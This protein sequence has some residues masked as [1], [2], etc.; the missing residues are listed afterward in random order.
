MSESPRIVVFGATGYTGRLTAER[1]VALGSR[2]VLAGRSLERL[3]ALAGQL[4]GLEAVRA[5]VLRQNSVFAMVREGDVVVSTVGPFVEWGEPAVRAAIASGAILLD[6]TGEPAF[7]RRVYTEFGPAARRAGATLLTAMG[8][9]YVPGALAGA[10]ALEEAGETA[11]RVDLGYYYFGGGPAAMSA[12]TRASLVGAALEPNFA[13]R[14]GR[15]RS[16]RVATRVRTFSV[17]G[18]DRSGVSIGGAEHFSLPLAYPRLRDVNVYLGWAGPLARGLQAGA[19]AGTVATRV[20]GVRGALRTAGR[21]VARL[22]PGPEPGT[23]PG[24]LSWV[25]AEAFDAAGHGSRRSSSRAS[26]ATTS[27][28]AHWRGRLGAPP[29]RASGAR[30]RSGRSTRSGSRLSRRAARRR[31]SPGSGEQA[32]RPARISPVPLYTLHREQH[33]P[34]TPDDVFR[35]SPT[36]GTSRRSPRPRCAS[37]SSRR[38]RSRCGWAP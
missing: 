19:L 7:I 15:I 17:K 23:V 34:G 14:A 38:A 33:L 30:A 1:L 6:S 37:R 35:S 28:R 27:P 13:Y 2:P 9:D 12:G 29:R 31:A 24:G 21:R 22:A 8:Y 20:P 16:E 36:P 3:D 18:K 26:T 11:V 32:A 4:G 5:D 25:V 10:L